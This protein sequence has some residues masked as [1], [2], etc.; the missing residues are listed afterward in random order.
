MM[1]PKRAI[2]AERDQTAA[3]FRR[4]LDVQA[5]SSLAQR[6]GTDG[7][8]PVLVVEPVEPAPEAGA[9]MATSTTSGE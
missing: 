8:L 2:T 6:Y 1:S 3:T 9:D 5:D 4:T 7:A